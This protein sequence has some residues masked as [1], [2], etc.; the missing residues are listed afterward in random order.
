MR[1]CVV[2]LFP[3]LLESFFDTGILGKARARG[4]VTLSTVNPR[5]FAVDKHRSVDD[6]PFGGGSGMVMMP[7]PVFGALESIAPL[8]EQHK[9]LMTPQGK[10]HDQDSAH[11]LCKHESLTLVCG[12]YEG[13]DER[14]RDAMDEEVSVGDFV[15]FG[16]EVAAMAVVESVAR[17]LPS[18]LGN[19]ASATDESHANG[20]LEYPHYTR[21]REFRGRLVPDVLLSGDH[22]AIDAWRKEQSLLRTAERRP[23][24]YQAWQRQP[25][26]GEKT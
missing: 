14:I 5:D 20:L 11:R 9:V 1:I 7:G 23:D 17:L 15:L 4:L 10:P 25:G 24:L 16:G 3:D 12:R 19:D 26:D 18:V 21:P 6:A 2:T 13:F 22:A 8:G